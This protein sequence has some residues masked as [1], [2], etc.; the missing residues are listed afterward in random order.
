[1]AKNEVK[2]KIHN[3]ETICYEEPRMYDVIFLNDDVTTED[4][5]VAVLIKY[6]GKTLDESIEIV[7]TINE[8]DMAVVGTYYRDVAE[9]KAQIVRDSARAEKFPFQVTT[10][11]V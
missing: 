10:K 3:K 8:E 9:T 2:E 11:E 1:M 7:D 6:F 5:V 4:F